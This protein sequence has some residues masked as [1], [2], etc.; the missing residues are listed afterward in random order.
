MVAFVVNLFLIP[1]FGASGT[2]LGILLAE[3]SVLVFQIFSLRSLLAKIWRRISII[4]PF[5]AMFIAVLATLAVRHFVQLGA[6]PLAA[7]SGTVFSVTYGS[8]LL[9][10]HDSF[11]VSMVSKVLRRTRV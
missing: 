11:T 8:A 6:F 9:A 1:A 5:A 3:L 10:M 7:L 4:K 2:S